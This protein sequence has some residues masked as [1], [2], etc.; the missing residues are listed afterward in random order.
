MSKDEII[1]STLITAY[2]NI[3]ASENALI[4]VMKERGIG[5]ASAPSNRKSSH[6]KRLQRLRETDGRIIK[7]KQ[8]EKKLLSKQSN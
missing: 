8:H 6:E 7:S 5:S 1:N 2:K 3:K 4:L